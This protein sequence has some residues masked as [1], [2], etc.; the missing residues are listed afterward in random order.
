MNLDKLNHEGSK[1]LEI[2][3]FSIFHS[4]FLPTKILIE[5]I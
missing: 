1:M 4:V 5:T 2:M 3:L